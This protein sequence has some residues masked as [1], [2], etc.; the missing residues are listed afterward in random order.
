MVLIILA[1]TSEVLGRKINL[2]AEGVGL[3]SIQ[4]IA[5]MDPLDQL[6]KARNLEALKTIESEVVRTNEYNQRV[7]AWMERNRQEL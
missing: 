5:N 6:A 4:V 1:V 2:E 7:S 3:G